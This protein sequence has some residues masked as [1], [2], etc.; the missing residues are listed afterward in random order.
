MGSPPPSTQTPS[1]PAPDTGPTSLPEAKPA[2]TKAPSKPS[3][4]VALLSA[5][6]LRRIIAGLGKRGIQQ[7][8][9]AKGLTKSAGDL[10]RWKARGK[11]YPSK[12]LTRD[13][14][15]RVHRYLRDSGNVDLLPGVAS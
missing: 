12:L 15:T 14:T 7:K 11:A 5:G 13:F 3:A 1:R 2:R 4:P 8:D 6:D 10:S 9:F